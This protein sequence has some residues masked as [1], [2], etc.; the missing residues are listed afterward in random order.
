[1]AEDFEMYYNASNLIATLCVCVCVCVDY[2]YFIYM[3][4]QVFCSF[5]IF[6]AMIPQNFLDRRKWPVLFAQHK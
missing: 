3:W 5:L 6:F 4:L 1:M 2:D